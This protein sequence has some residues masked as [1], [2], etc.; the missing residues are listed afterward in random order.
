MGFENRPATKAELA[1]MKHL[2]EEGMKAG[3]IGL[4]IGLLYSP[5]RYSS[6]EELAELCEVLPAYNGLF[7]THIRGEGNHLIESIQE[8]IW[9][10]EKAGIS[11]HISHLKAA[12]KR[13]WGLVSQ[14]LEMIEDSRARGFDVTCDVYPY[15][16]GSTMLS[17]VLPPWTLEGGMEQCLERLSQPDVRE[18]IKQELSVEQEDWDNLVAS[19]GWDSVIISAVS[20]KNEH[21]EGES[22]ASISERLGKDPCETVL[23]LLLQEDG[24]VS[25]VFFHMANEDVEH[26]LQSDYSL[27]IS[28]SLGCSTGKPH[29][30]TYGTFPRIFD[31]YVREKK[32]FIA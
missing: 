18:R 8:V 14:A 6:K 3:A 22:I 28:D 30:R 20:P 23:D 31:T 11:L 5:G 32:D 4:S 7:S 13:N 15:E 27:I 10:A 9:I 2:L 25:I 12:G 21:L 16:A 17:T 26:V 1:Q 19:T 29:P 24:N